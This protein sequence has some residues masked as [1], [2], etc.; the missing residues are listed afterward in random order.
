MHIAM[1]ISIQSSGM[2]LFEYRLDIRALP[3]T[4]PCRLNIRTK[5]NLFASRFLH[6]DPGYLISHLSQVKGSTPSLNITWKPKCFSSHVRDAKDSKVSEKHNS[7]KFGTNNSPFKAV[8]LALPLSRTF[9]SIKPFVESQRETILKAWL[10]AVISVG[11][12]FLAVPRIGE[13]SGLLAAGD[14]RNLTKKAVFTMTLVL[15][16]SV[17]R[18]FQQALLWEAALDVTYEIRSYVFQRVLNRDLSYFEGAGGT[19]TGDIAYRITAES[20]DTADTVYALLHT[21][22]PSTLQLIAMGLRM[23]FLSPILSLATISV[24]PCMSLV[25]A[26]F[27]EKLRKISRKGQ[28]SIAVLSSYLNEVLPSMII[29]KAYNA[30]DCEQ[31]RFEKL[32]NADRNAHISKKKLKAFIPEVITSVYA[33]TSLILFLVGSWVISCGTFNGAGMVSFVTS[34]VLLIEPIQDLGKSYNELKQG[35]PAIERLFELAKFC[36]QVVDEADMVPLASVA[37]D[38]KFCNIT[39]HYGDT[40]PPVLSNLSFDV[41]AGETVAIVGPSGGGKTTL[42][43]LLLRLY[44]PSDGCILVDGHDIR[45]VS[46]KSLRQC[47]VL[48]PQDI[49][50]FAGTVA[51]NIGYGKIPDKIDMKKVEQAAKLANADGFI[52]KLSE[53]Y[54]TNV[55]QRGSCLSGG[56]RQRLAIAR[57][58]YQEASILILDEATSALDNRSELLVREA[59]E[60]LMTNRTVFV[61]AHRLETV[62]KADRI[63]LLDGGKLVEEGTHSSLLAQ[64]GQYASLYSRKE[65]LT[66]V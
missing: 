58:I 11:S 1:E 18:Y 34:L 51:E 9:E 23:F 63:I 13:L 57:A 8:T 41:K 12:L 54:D 48:V 60:H 40:H 17:A 53:G 43:K 16:R 47:I 35:E 21:V 7:S 55:G 10:C 28:E 4:R 49:A 29:V 6:R 61:I 27:G 14:L 59:V 52:Q 50:L 5:P 39:F 33:G 26:Y 45:N 31:H 62:R 2:A 64:G 3:Q 42:A 25:I 65:L 20:K 44:D 15:S 37:G 56:Q 46:L 66:G 30:E 24:I 36:P 38:V 19:L 32:A 22:V